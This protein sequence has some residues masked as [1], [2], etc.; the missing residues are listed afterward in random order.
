ML[1][2]ILRDHDPFSPRT[3]RELADLAEKANAEFIVVTD[4]D[5][6]KLRA[7]PDSTW[8]CPLVRPELAVAF[9]SGREE[10]DRLVLGAVGNTGRGT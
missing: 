5:W 8:P 4:K 2:R 1:N 7:L 9:D 6:S 10:F 3:V